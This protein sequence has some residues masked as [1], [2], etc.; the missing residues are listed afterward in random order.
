MRLSRRD[1]E[2]ALEFVQLASSA[3]G[4][5]PFPRPVVESLAQLVPGQ[6]VAYH[7]WDLRSREVPTMAV[8]VPVASTPRHVAEARRHFCRTYPLS[9]LRLNGVA[10]PSAISDFISLRLLHRLD[11]YD[12]VLRPS[13][14]EHQMRLWLPASPTVSRVFCFNRRSTD[15]DFGEREHGLLE[16]LR[17]FLAATRERFELRRAG[18]PL[19]VDGLTER[20]AEILTW[21]ARGKTNHEIA[22]LLVVS[23]HTV[24]KHLENIYAKLDVHTRTAAVARV[25]APFDQAPSR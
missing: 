3:D 12:Y 9:I 4:P 11:Y 22:V 1:L 8:E 2:R 16:L 10:R 7:E 17:P 25:A 14:V 19:T 20:E 23:A 21:V 18:P 24:R 6:S 13:G 5:E 15:H